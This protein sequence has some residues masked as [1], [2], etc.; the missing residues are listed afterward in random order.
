M[1]ALF[2]KLMY[3]ELIYMFLFLFI[4]VTFQCVGKSIYPSECFQIQFY[5]IFFT[6]KI[7]FIFHLEPPLSCK[8]QTVMLSKNWRPSCLIGIKIMFSFSKFESWLHLHSKFKHGVSFSSI[9][10]GS[11]CNITIYTNNTNLCYVYRFRGFICLSTFENCQFKSQQ[12]GM[13]F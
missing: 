11:R 6:S 12:R 4:R 8:V 2:D 3:I 10:V 5:N 1:F 13:Q 9:H 7:I